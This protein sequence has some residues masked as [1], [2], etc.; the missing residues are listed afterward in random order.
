MDNSSSTKDY[1][2]KKEFSLIK[3][4]DTWK[5][6]NVNESLFKDGKINMVW[7]QISVKTPDMSGVE[8]MEGLNIISP[9]WFELRNDDNVLGVKQSDPVVFSNWQGKIHMVDM[10]DMDYMN[11]A[12]KTGTMYGGFLEMN[13]I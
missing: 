3:I 2:G 12:A 7:D 6:Y 8:P 5:V 4:N 1:K 13:L 10:G 11:W 9:T